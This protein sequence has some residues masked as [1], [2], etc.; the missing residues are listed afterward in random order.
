MNSGAGQIFDIQA[1]ICAAII[2][3]AVPMYL[4]GKKYRWFWCRHNLIKIFHLE[5]DHIGAEE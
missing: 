3:T 2:L 5:T 4:F 1:G